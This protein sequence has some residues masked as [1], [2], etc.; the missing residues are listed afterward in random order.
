V[1]KS[2]DLVEQVAFEQGVPVKVV[3]D[4]INK[5]ILFMDH[6]ED[7]RDFLCIKVPHIGNYKFSLD[8]SY[9]LLLNYKDVITKFKIEITPEKMRRLYLNEKRFKMVK[10]LMERPVFKKTFSLFKGKVSNTLCKS[11]MTLEQLEEFQN[12]FQC[13]KKDN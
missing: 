12:N 8:N 3:R 10:K 11:K 5:S 1:I 4:I 6:I 2:Q 7:N 9:R 13:E